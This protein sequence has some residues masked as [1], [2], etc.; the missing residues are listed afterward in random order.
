MTRVINDL[1]GQPHFESRTEHRGTTR[2]NGAAVQEY[3][4]YFR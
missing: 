1:L 3:S 2:M 4:Q